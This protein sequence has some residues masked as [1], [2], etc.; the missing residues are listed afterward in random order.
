MNTR[1]KTLYS[2]A[3]DSSEESRDI[4]LASLE[5]IGRST[6][7]DVAS[8][9]LSRANYGRFILAS[10]FRPHL[11]ASVACGEIW[12]C[13]CSRLGV[14][15][16][17][18]PAINVDEYEN[19]RAQSYRATMDFIK[20]KGKG[21]PPSVEPKITQ[22][23]FGDVAIKTSTSDSH[24]EKT[25]ATSWTSFLP[26][27]AGFPDKFLD[28]SSMAEILAAKINEWCLTHF[29]VGRRTWDKLEIW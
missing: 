7:D 6:A 19:N 18:T 22:E 4:V 27:G 28:Q 11:N 2:I 3:G 13:Y 20:S 16:V 9:A 26:S 25:L 8:R 5:A 1:P 21:Q 15:S 24:E 12:A 17:C 29:M 23:G 14:D 10:N